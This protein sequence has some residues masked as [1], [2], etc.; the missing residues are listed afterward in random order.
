MGRGKD[1]AR[2]GLSVKSTLAH[3]F[4]TLPTL[5][6]P[7][8]PASQ[9]DSLLRW[10]RFVQNFASRCKKCSSTLQRG[11]YKAGFSPGTFLCNRHAG[12][13]LAPVP[14]AQESRA[15][16]K[17]TTASKTPSGNCGKGL[18]PPQAASPVP[19]PRRVFQN[20][21]APQPAAAQPPPSSWSP[22]IGGVSASPSLSR[23]HPPA[24]SADPPMASSST[25]VR[26]R[27]QQAREKFFQADP[28]SSGFPVRKPEPARNHSSS[29]VQPAQVP[30][31]TPVSRTQLPV[32]SSSTS[33]SKKDQA[34]SILQ[35]VLPGPQP[36]TSQPGGV[37]STAVPRSLAYN[38]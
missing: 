12:A 30:E 26:S 21:V 17:T 33:D 2:I 36:S 8:F 34:R 24:P 32:S 10:S 9:S 19:K 13:E 1:A 23:P 4:S 5:R 25:E 28:A 16:K 11:N 31:K 37:S 6:L 38:R 29:P 14:P 18:A 20:N 3:S 27:I 15:E 35:R 22:K 7:E